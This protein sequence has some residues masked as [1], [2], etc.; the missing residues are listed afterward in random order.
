M[1]KSLALILVLTLVLAVFT[2]VGCGNTDDNQTEDPQVDALK[3]A[4]VV[5]SGFGD[6]SFNDSAK[7]GADLLV[8]DYGIDLKTI[9]CNGENFKQ[10]MMDAADV[11]EVV[12]CVGW[13]FYEIEEV[14]DEYPEVKFMWIDNESGEAHDNLL[15]IIYAQNEGS[16]LAGYVAGKLTTSN[17]VGAVGGEDSTTINDFI[18]GY[19][20]GAKYAN[21]DVE[22]VYNYAGDY[23]NP[24]LGKELA[25]ALKDKGADVIFQV[26]GNT[27][28][29]VIEAAAENGFYAIGVDK[30]Q[31]IEFPNYDASII[32]SMLK[33][34]GTSIYDVVGAYI[35]DGTFEGGSTWVAD[36]KNN[37]IDLAYG[38]ADSIQQVPDELKAEIETLKTQIVSGEIV[39]DTTR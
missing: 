31:K 26:A 28:S 15:N 29:G 13:E 6:K 11:A 21:P 20:Q 8:K 23:E 2:F 4:L 27:G 18:V 38:D 19:E 22:V 10:N 5:P 39:V 1:K 24:A 12:I 14:V 34:V 17:V 35:K 37:Y 30:D 7:D 32:C 16:F 36:M 25:L 3:V 33:Q 9:E